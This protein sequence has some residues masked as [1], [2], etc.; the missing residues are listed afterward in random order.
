MNKNDRQALAVAALLSVG[1]LAGCNTSEPAPPTPESTEAVSED[2]SAVPDADEA[3]ADNGEV[4]EEPVTQSDIPDVEFTVDNAQS[5]QHGVEVSV[6]FTFEGSME[7][8]EGNVVRAVSRAI[9][10]YPDYD[11][12]IVRGYGAGSGP[13]DGSPTIEAWFKPDNVRSLDLDNPAQSE[14]YKHCYSCHVPGQ[15]HR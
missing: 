1:L 6:S 4:Q 14:P 5:D 11:L 2:G 12:I 15:H 3:E 9:E 10:E 8:N 7:T 13:S